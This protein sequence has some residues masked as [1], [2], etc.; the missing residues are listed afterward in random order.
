MWNDV[1]G[2]TQKR[3]KK[4]QTESL[5][6]RRVVAEIS[7]QFW[8]NRA[9]PL[10]CSSEYRSERGTGEWRSIALWCWGMG[11]T[12]HL[13]KVK[14]SILCLVRWADRMLLWCPTGEWEK[15]QI[16]LIVIIAKRGG[17]WLVTPLISTG[18]TN[19]S[20]S[21]SSA[22]CCY[23]PL[24]FKRQSLP[25]RSPH[26]RPSTSAG[27]RFRSQLFILNIRRW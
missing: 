23:W 22:E 1:K 25:P 12:I 18:W 4:N 3:A 16:I 21:S 14:T 5:K 2:N 8:R 20:S 17:R 9:D 15:Y 27:F 6:H 26:W 24:T 13:V 10:V 11:R 19:C 7:K